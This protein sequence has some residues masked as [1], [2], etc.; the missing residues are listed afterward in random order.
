MSLSLEG[1]CCVFI[2]ASIDA[3]CVRS[4]EASS[5]KRQSMEHEHHT[6]MQHVHHSHL[7]HALFQLRTRK[8]CGEM[9]FWFLRQHQ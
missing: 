1:C 9:Y 8:R 6:H 5:V 7:L 4:L 2:Q 3:S